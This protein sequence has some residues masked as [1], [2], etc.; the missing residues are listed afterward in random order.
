MIKVAL[1]A[2]W[3]ILIFIILSAV[4]VYTILKIYQMYKK[5]PPKK[6][7]P[8]P[9]IDLDSMEAIVQNKNSDE[10]ALISVIKALVA[11]HKIPPKNGDKVDKLAKRYLDLIFTM[12]SH[13]NMSSELQD[14]MYDLLSEANPSYIRDFGRARRKR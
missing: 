5:P 3:F 7:Q 6:K 11:H 9:N 2:I 8:V 13:K 14:E 1:I 12:A 4:F 10:L